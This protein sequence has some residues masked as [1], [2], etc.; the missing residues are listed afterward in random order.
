MDKKFATKA[1][2]AAVRVIVGTSMVG[3]FLANTLP[4]THSK[5]T[6][7]ENVRL[8]HE[9]FDKGDE[10]V[11]SAVPSR[12]PVTEN[13][14]TVYAEPDETYDSNSQPAEEIFVDTSQTTEISSPATSIEPQEILQQETEVQKGLININTAS[15]SELMTLSGI[16]EVKAQAIIDYRE[17]N[18]AFVCV[19]DITLVKGIG[20]KTLEKIRDEI[21]V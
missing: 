7:N 5:M 6:V 1:L 16:G 14:V 20:D 8:T 19:D 15:K 10:N 3:V 11:L 2:K 4:E 18:G 9:V 21:T 13:S 17:S 12:L